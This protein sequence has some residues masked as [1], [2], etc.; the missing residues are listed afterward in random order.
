MI[1]WL[2]DRCEF[3]ITEYGYSCAT[4]GQHKL[5]CRY[6]TIP[7]DYASYCHNLNHTLVNT[8]AI[9]YDT[10]NHQSIIFQKRK[11][12]FVT[13]LSNRRLQFKHFKWLCC[14]I[15]QSK[16]NSQIVHF[17]QFPIIK[18]WWIKFEMWNKSQHTIFIGEM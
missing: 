3:R 6:N 4:F 14:H 2:V 7:S 5:L 18:S 10:L 12:H 17:R 1:D 16:T 8:L 13:T 9:L 15:I 11:Y